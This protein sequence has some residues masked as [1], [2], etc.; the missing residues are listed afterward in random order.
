M[1]KIIALLSALF[2]SAIFVTGCASTKLALKDNSPLAIVTIVGNQIVAKMP[3]N[4]RSKFTVGVREMG[5][6]YADNG[7]VLQIWK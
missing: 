4:Y 6:K 7:G 1:K 2:F 5:W 3:L